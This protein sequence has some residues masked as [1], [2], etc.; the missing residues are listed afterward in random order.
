MTLDAYLQKAPVGAVNTLA[1]KLGV[2]ATTVSKYRYGERVPPLKVALKIAEATGG[3]VSVTELAKAHAG[4]RR[5]PL[6][7]R[8]RKTNTPKQAG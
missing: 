6:I 8:T 3:L 7:H 5:K 4:R 2:T 1:D